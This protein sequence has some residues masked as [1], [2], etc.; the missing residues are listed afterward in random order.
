MQALKENDDSR[1][2]LYKSQVAAS[3]SNVSTLKSRVL[4]LEEQLLSQMRKGCQALLHFKGYLS[5]ESI[6]ETGIDQQT[7]EKVLWS[8]VNKSL[9][10]EEERALLSNFYDKGLN[11]EQFIPSDLQKLRGLLLRLMPQLSLQDHLPFESLLLL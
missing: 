3:D 10:G 7:I 11:K 5:E 2:K 9:I 4:E 8:C 1:I 6:K